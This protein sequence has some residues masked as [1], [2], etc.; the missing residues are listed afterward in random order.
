M[1]HS[2]RTTSILAFNHI[3]ALSLSSHTKRKS[4]ELLHILDR[5]T[6]INRAGDL[7][8]FT[9]ITVY[10]DVAVAVGVFV[11]RFELTL[12]M[13]VG[14]VMV[15]YIWA[16]VVLTRYRTKIRRQMNDQDVVST[17][18]CYFLLCMHAPCIVLLSTWS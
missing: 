9:M 11:L 5:V 3:L 18:I 13:V 7:I 16:S 15:G 2:D 6:A 8:Y 14:V 17:C 10:L 4:G 1:H 12:G